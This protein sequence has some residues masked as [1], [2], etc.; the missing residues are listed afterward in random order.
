MKSLQILVVGINPVAILKNPYYR[1]KIHPPRLQGLQEN[2][3]GRV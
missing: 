1:E 2:A 3:S